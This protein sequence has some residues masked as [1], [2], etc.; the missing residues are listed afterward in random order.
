M[1]EPGRIRLC[2]DC[3]RAVQICAMEDVMAALEE[4]RRK[5]EQNIEKN[6]ADEWEVEPA[7]EMK[8]LWAAYERYKEAG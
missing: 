6:W 7:G 3:Q 8:L 5:R 4:V 1:N 2:F